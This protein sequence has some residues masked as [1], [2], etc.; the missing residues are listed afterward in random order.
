MKNENRLK[1]GIILDSYFVENWKIESL[2]EILK[3][4]N[5]QLE[6][7][8]IN[9]SKNS[10]FFEELFRKFEAKRCK[11]FPS[12]LAKKELKKFVKFNNEI[13][14]EFEKNENNFEFVKNDEELIKKFNLDVL[15]CYDFI[16][17]E[18]KNMNDIQFGLWNLKFP[19]SKN[20]PGFNEVI[21]EKQTTVCNFIIDCK[22]FQKPKTFLE[23]HSSTDS[24]YII[25]NQNNLFWK[26]GS[27]FPRTLNYI[28]IHGKQNF[29]DKLNQKKDF[30][31]DQFQKNKKIGIIEF[32]DAFFSYSK[33][34]LKIK[35]Y[36]SRYWEQ[37]CL[38]YNINKELS[39]DFQNF[40]KI[41]PPQDKFW[42]DPQ[43]IVHNGKNHVFFEEFSKSKN[44][45]HI[46]TMTIDENGHSEPK[47]IIEESHHL[48]YPNIFKFEDTFYMIPESSQKRTID[49]YKCEKFPLKWKF[50]KTL[51]KNVTA[52]D[53]TIFYFNKKWWLF[54]VIAM[55]EGAIPGDELFLFYSDTPI[56]T[57]W[58]PH[59]KNPIISDV[60][61][62]RP[63]G[64]IFEYER[65]IIRPTQN[66]MKGYGHA[67]NLNEIQKLTENE[68]EEKQF[69]TLEPN[70]NEK[71][72]AIHTFEYNNGLTIIDAKIQQLN[73]NG[74]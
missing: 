33:K 72:K 45:G 64:H 13:E 16:D 50:E 66:S 37:F 67:I 68:F 10:T 41:I 4:E 48:S 36:D 7:L 49:L 63:G 27:F 11:I 43:L 30:E 62:A 40:K 31:L 1:I 3:N 35:K 29:Y 65:K 46:C 56:S 20:T 34:Y 39:F 17:L 26:I 32:F 53:N 44:K 74:N 59:P 58:T 15:L 23:S 18:F 38:L 14:I 73:K 52:V 69:K 5:N 42:A 47:K 60:R 2:K 55:I 70:W 22:K 12:A 57:E 9:N 71:V 8:I 21:T 54:S 19:Y 28:Q 25:R 61:N 51:M 24:L 6:L